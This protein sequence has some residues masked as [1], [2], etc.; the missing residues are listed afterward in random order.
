MS[1]LLPMLILLPL[2]GGSLLLFFA[3]QAGY[4]SFAKRASWLFSGLT[5]L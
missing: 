5:L 2:V 4:D 1:G 3:T